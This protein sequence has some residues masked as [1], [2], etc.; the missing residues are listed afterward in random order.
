LKA[1]V[2]IFVVL[3]IGALLMK[4]FSKP[5]IIADYILNI[6]AYKKACINKSKP[7]MACNGK[8]QMMKKMGSNKSSNETPVPPDKPNFDYTPLSSKSFFPDVQSLVVP[9]A[10]AVPFYLLDYHHNFASSLFHPPIA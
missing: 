6:D 7:K 4:D 8:C 2:K 10:K 9:R 3:I 5:L 1:S